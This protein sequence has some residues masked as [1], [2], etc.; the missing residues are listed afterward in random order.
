MKKNINVIIIGCG[1]IGYR[2]LE[3]II[4]LNIKMNIFIIEKNKKRLSQIKKKNLLSN[5]KNI[6]IHFFDE[7]DNFGLIFYFAIIATNSQ[8]RLNLVKKLLKNNKIQHLLLEKLL[9]YNFNQLLSLKKYLSTVST[10]IYVN[11][12]RRFMEVYKNIKK[13]I[14]YKKPII[15]EYKGNKWNF[16]SNSIHFIDLFCFLSEDID[17]NCTSLRILK[18]RYSKRKNYSEFYGFCYFINS[19]EG[20]LY[21]SD[22][23]K[24]AKKSSSTI[25][26][27]NL[28]NSFF[29]NE[30]DGYY[31]KKDNKLDKIIDKKNFKFELQSKLTEKYIKYLIQGKKLT[32]TTF[33]ESFF[34]HYHFYKKFF[35][36]IKKL[37]YKNIKIS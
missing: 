12:P 37:K 5:K 23:S 15:I 1:N 18:K 34:H 11:T 14:D 30:I 31:Y 3:S 22:S 4:N 7:I 21:L 6:K 8:D 24:T 20:S 33:E 2:H 10:K 16:S 17:I 27:N 29:I 35:N 28:K 19:K 13:Q 9:A 36:E 26:I 25:K 32:L